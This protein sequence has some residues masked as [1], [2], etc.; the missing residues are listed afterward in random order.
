[1]KKETRLARN[2]S[3]TTPPTT[4]PAMAPVSVLE[5]G[6]G[7]NEGFGVFDGNV[8]L[9]RAGARAVS[10]NLSQSDRAHDRR[11]NLLV[12]K[13]MFFRRAATLE[14]KLL[15]QVLCSISFSRIV[16]SLIAGEHTGLIQHRFPLRYHSAHTAPGPQQYNYLQA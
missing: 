13:C 1:M 6:G 3:S 12:G 5:E 9:L 16:Y 11:S 4:P 2:A 10:K 15:V 8:V 14:F 7:F